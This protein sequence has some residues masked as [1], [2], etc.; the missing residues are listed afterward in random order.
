[1]EEYNITIYSA[2]LQSSFLLN[3]TRL[4]RNPG[5]YD[6]RK[7]LSFFYVLAK[8]EKKRLIFIDFFMFL[9]NNLYIFHIIYITLYLDYRIFVSFLI[10]KDRS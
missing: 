9:L 7:I 3:Y 8:R 10:I 5:H 6:K 1:M 2:P 4:N